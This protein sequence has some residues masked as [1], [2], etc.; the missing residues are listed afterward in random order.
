M[1][2]NEILHQKTLGNVMKNKNA[3]VKDEG[4]PDCLKG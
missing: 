3:G 2:L 4:Y 1:P